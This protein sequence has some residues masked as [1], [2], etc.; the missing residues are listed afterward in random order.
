MLIIQESLESEDRSRVWTLLKRDFPDVV[1]Q[2]KRSDIEELEED[3][4][5]PA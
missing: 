5:E 4:A 1:A 3:L 2:A